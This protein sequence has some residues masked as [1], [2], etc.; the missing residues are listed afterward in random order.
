MNVND[1]ILEIAKQP[2]KLHQ[3]SPRE[4]EEIVAE[5][6]AGF[7]WEVSLTS[8]T[9]D[10]GYD[11]LGVVKDAPGLESTWVVE[12][13]K[14]GATNKVGI[15][16]ARQLYGVKWNLG[17][18]NALLVTTST[19][20]NGVQQLGAS[21]YDLSLVDY[22]G[23]L[24]WI[25]AYTGRPDH[26][27]YLIGKRFYSC[28]ISY[29]HKDEEF[30]KALN[31]A[32]RNEGIRVW[33]APED[34]L[35]GEKLHEQISGAIESHDR[36]LV[37]M[38]EASMESE[39]VKT[40]IRKARRREVEEKSRVLFP[41]SLAPMDKIKKWECFDADTGKDL[42]V[43]IREYYIPDFSTWRDKTSFEKQLKKL[44]EGLNLIK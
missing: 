11:I 20:T 44:V 14:Y 22:N 40:E 33:F 26:L 42:G 7:G 16:L 28:F 3:I 36:L 39:W 37:I 21:K 6:L 2:E 8:R 19:F 9:K 1:L 35:P 25:H 31:S 15:E 4:F 24:N 10:G 12:C 41:I 30:A 34:M 5:L 29:S 32:L 43:E 23:I 18:S 17:V 27:P 13:K 38:S